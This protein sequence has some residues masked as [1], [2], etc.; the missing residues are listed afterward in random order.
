LHA[1]GLDELVTTSLDD[2]EALALRLA[3]EPEAVAQLRA[4]LARNRQT[5]PLFNTARFTRNLEAAYQQMLETWKAGRP[6]TAFAVSPSLDAGW[7]T[8]LS[9]RETYNQTLRPA[10]RSVSPA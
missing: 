7:L 8:D 10:S 5:Y 2:Y 6:P 1:I 9:A 3:R 4:R